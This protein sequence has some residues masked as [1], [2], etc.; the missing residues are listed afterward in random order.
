VGSWEIQNGERL[1]AQSFKRLQPGKGK[2]NENERTSTVEY[3]CTVTTY[4]TYVKAGDGEPQIV[5]QYEVWDCE[6]TFIPETVAPPSSNDPDTGGTDPG[7]YEPHPDF[8]G[9]MVPCGSLDQDCPCCKVPPSERVLCEHQAPPCDDLPTYSIEIQNT[10][11][12]TGK[13][14]GR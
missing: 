3:H 2:G 4:T 14:S 6:F 7:C 12:W 13:N 8:E 11:D 5:E 1:R 9:F 10:A